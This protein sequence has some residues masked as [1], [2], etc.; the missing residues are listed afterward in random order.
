MPTSD[1]MEGIRTDTARVPTRTLVAGVRT[2]AEAA[3]R[4]LIAVFVLAVVAEFLLAG[5]GAFG[6][7][8]GVALGDQRSWDPHR[9]LGYLLIGAALLLLVVCLAWWSERIWLLAT[10]LLAVLAFLQS[11]LAHVGLHHRWIGALHP[12]N[13]V[14]I[15]GLSAYLAQRAWRG[16]LV[17]R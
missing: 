10:F 3:Y 16:D 4:W 5:A 1:L 6:Q 7:K 11:V 14:A 2:V 12:L 8:T 13:A 17:A 15:L 9:A